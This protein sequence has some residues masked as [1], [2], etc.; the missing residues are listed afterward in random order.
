MRLSINTDNKEVFSS[1]VR[2][3]LEVPSTIFL[4]FVY[5]AIPT[6]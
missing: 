6:V 1:R 4:V 5:F 3:V 2:V